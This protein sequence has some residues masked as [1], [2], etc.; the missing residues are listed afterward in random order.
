MVCG[1]SITLGPPLEAQLCCSPTTDSGQDPPLSWPP[2]P[3][4]WLC[5]PF[6]A[7]AFCNFP[8]NCAFHK[9]FMKLAA[10]VPH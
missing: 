6:V 9:G 7:L 1:W 8:L 2:F 4:L 5:E 3:H 10:S